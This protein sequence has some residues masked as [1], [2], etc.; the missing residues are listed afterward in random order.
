MNYLLDTNTCIKYLNGRSKEIRNNLESK[1]QQDIFVCSIVKA[2]LFYG[3]M[4][5]KNP[6]KNL[7]K[8]TQFLNRFVSLAFDDKASEV[9][10]QI[11]A[12]L[13]KSGTPIGPNDLFIAAIAI[14]NNITLVTNNTREF[15]RVEDLQFEDWE[16][17]VVEN[18]EVE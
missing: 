13:E 18:D 6:E 1:S 16:I 4:K 9:Y 17:Y 8:Q 5:S 12:R 2:E 3:A 10:G 11:R 15:G 7:E 14:S